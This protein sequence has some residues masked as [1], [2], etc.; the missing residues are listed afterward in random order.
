M[1]HP[2][3]RIQRIFSHHTGHVSVN[4]SS[5]HRYDRTWKGKNTH[6]HYSI[7][8]SLYFVLTTENPKERLSCLCFYQG[9]I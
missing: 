1:F 2:G 5:V 9:R 7:F 3:A 8:R 4:A 6:C